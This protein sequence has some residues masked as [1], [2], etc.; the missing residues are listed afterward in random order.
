VVPWDK[1]TENLLNSIK[2][3]YI[4]SSGSSLYGTPYGTIGAASSL[5]DVYLAVIALMQVLVSDF[6]D[7]SA[8][9]FKKRF[10]KNVT[11]K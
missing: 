6:L 5:M 1:G 8:Y 9:R 7:H 11:P 4:P 2:I 10:N 3:D